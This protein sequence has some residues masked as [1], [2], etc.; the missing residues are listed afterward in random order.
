MAFFSLQAGIPAT[1]VTDER[2]LKTYREIH[3]STDDTPGDVL[4]ISVSRA[5]KEQLD[6]LAQST[7]QDRS[8]IALDA[9][10]AYVTFEAEQLAKIHRGVADADA[11]RFVTDEEMEASFNRYQ[12]YRVEQAG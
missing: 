8:Q 7:G 3:M 5:L 11:G 9:V 1:Y 2:T 10:S 6:N 4:Q 12:P